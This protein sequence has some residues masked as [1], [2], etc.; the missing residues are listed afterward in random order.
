[1]DNVVEIKLHKRLPDL[2]PEQEK[3]MH[4]IMVEMYHRGYADAKA[5]LCEGCSYKSYYA[6][7]AAQSDCN[8]CG[9]ARTC[10]DR[11]RPGGIVRINCPLW[12]PRIG[13]QCHAGR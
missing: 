12:R 11:P 4:E 9:K 13:G 7:V 3:V 10:A 5:K 1:M 6:Q 8:D 2:T